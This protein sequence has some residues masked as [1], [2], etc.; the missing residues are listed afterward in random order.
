ME[1][2]IAFARSLS[3]RSCSPGVSARA[4]VIVWSSLCYRALFAST[5]SGAIVLT[6]KLCAASM[7]PRYFKAAVNKDAPP[8]VYQR[9]SSVVRTNCMDCLD[10]TNV[11]QSV[12]SRWVLSRQLQE[13]GILAPGEQFESHEQFEHLFRNG[14][15]CQLFLF[16]WANAH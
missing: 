4:Q 5:S 15:Y 11:V 1:S 8:R 2:C 6:W 3:P 13:L 14:K 7:S 10:R 9:Q 12:I 16:L